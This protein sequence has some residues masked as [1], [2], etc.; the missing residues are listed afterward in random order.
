MRKRINESGLV[1]VHNGLD[2]V[3][4][5]GNQGEQ[6]MKKLYRIDPEELNKDYSREELLELIKKCEV[7]NYLK[8]EEPLPCPKCDNGINECGC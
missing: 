3:L 4:D 1:E 6:P 2:W 8:N 7:Y 5:D